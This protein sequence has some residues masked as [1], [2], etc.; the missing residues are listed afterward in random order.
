LDSAA[1]ALAHLPAPKGR[2][3]RNTLLWG[4][5]SLTVID[6]SYNASPVSVRAALATLGSFKPTAGGRRIAVLGDMRELGVEGPAL[7]RALAEAALAAGI[8]LVFTAG[9]LMAELH[10]ALPAD[11]RGAHAT[12]SEALAPLVS[13]AVRSGDLVMIK[14][15]AGSRMNKVVT[16][17]ESMAAP[18]P[19]AANGH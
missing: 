3:A 2:G 9:P 5:G 8:D 18:L 16:H 1:S 15:S 17:L 6:D 4:E 13:D 7:H 14:G 12:D 19:P 10:N 11:R